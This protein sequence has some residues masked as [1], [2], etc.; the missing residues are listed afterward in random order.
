MCVFAKCHRKCVAII[1]KTHTKRQL[2]ER[3][4]FMSKQQGEANLY[5]V[6]FNCAL[7]AIVE[8]CRYLVTTYSGKLTTDLFRVG[9]LI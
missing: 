7:D 4:T 8:N 3:E 9:M 2:N 6:S 5:F 1:S